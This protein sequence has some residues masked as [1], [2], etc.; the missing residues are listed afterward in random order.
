M[1][2]V[3]RF[4]AR[5]DMRTGPDGCWLWTG[6]LHPYG[7]ISV[8]GR[9]QGAH[10]FA[11]ELVHG[12]LFENAELHHICRNKGCVNPDHLMALT[13]AAHGLL[14][15]RYYKTHC[16]HG[17]PFDD[18]NTYIRPDGYKGCRT[19]FRE[20]ARKRA[21]LREPATPKTHCIHGHEFTPDNTYTRN[22]GRQRHCRECAIRRAR[23]YKA[24]KRAE[25]AEA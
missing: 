16:I 23:E 19:C 14:D 10:R 7:R 2:A 13:R 1:S 15:G 24:K 4:I 11:Y 9:G 18:E 5:A 8:E 12:P 21:S 17:H 6:S 3:E 22:G 20:R 25:K